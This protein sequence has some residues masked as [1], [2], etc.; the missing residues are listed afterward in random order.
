[1]SMPSYTEENWP[2]KKL[3]GEN[4]AKGR[5]GQ[6]ALQKYWNGKGELERLDLKGKSKDHSRPKI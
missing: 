6:P 1:L 5:G 2:W 3:S 4:Y